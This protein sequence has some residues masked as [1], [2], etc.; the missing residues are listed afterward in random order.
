MQIM[1]FKKLDEAIERANNTEYG[2]AA[3]VI[4]KDL[5]RAL[6]VAHSVRAGS[7]WWESKNRLGT[8]PWLSARLWYLIEAEWRIYASVN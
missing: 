5:E 3:S 4:T 6:H 7:V 2:L 8:Y 1:K